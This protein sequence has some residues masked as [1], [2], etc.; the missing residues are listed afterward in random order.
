ME[1]KIR[2]FE[3]AVRKAD[4]EYH[5]N[6]MKAEATRQDWEAAI[7]KVILDKPQQTR[8]IELILS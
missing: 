7:F 2:Q 5:E 8:N 6:C 4:K 1:K 3:D